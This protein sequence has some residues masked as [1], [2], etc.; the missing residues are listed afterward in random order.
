M[1][2]ARLLDVVFE[3]L[4]I[5]VKALAKWGIKA[6]L[7]DDGQEI[8][9]HGNITSGCAASADPITRAV[10]LGFAVG[11]SLWTHAF[12]DLLKRVREEWKRRSKLE[13]AGKDPDDEPQQLTLV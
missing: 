12:P 2:T 4:E 9:I 13:Q 1:C 7:L 8:R 5:W 6:D 3:P 10:I 11:G